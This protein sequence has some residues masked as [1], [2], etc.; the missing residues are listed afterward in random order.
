[1]MTNGGRK[2]RPVPDNLFRLPY[3]PQWFER[4]GGERRLYRTEL[5]RAACV[6]RLRAVLTPQWFHWPFGDEE[7]VR[8]EVDSFSFYCFP[9]DGGWGMIFGIPSVALYGKF[10]SEADGGTRIDVRQTVPKFWF[11]QLLYPVAALVVTVVMAVMVLRGT[12]FFAGDTGRNA[13]MLTFLP[14]SI[15]VTALGVKRVLTQMEYPMFYVIARLLEA[16]EVEGVTFDQ[17]FDWMD[18]RA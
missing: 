10:D 1:M 14:F 18:L 9:V 11:W 17:P 4:L 6:E 13:M 5:S 2:W 15:I 3:R 16:E 12:W 8:G 7:Q